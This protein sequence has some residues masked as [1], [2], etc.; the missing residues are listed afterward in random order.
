MV[1]HLLVEGNSL[2]SI[3]R[4]T[5]VSKQTI[6]NLLRQVGSACKDFSRRRIRNVK[7]VDLQLD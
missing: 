1:I 7:V 3:E 5:N 6:I 4:L 2:R